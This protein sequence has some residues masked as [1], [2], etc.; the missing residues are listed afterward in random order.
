MMI[1]EKFDRFDLTE[2]AAAVAADTFVMLTGQLPI[3]VVIRFCYAQFSKLRL[4]FA[5]IPCGITCCCPDERLVL[6]A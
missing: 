4:C 6:I 2:A 3:D 1:C 5:G